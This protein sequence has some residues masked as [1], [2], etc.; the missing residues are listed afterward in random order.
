MTLTQ[1]A[2][3]AN[4]Y[5]VKAGGHSSTFCGKSEYSVAGT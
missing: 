4:C 5:L 3:D 2:V 1:N